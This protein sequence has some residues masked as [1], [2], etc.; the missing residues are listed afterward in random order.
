MWWLVT[1]GKAK[2]NSENWFFFLPVLLG[3]LLEYFTLEFGRILLFSLKSKVSEN[4][5]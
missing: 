5:K 2:Q 1:L 4:A 3:N